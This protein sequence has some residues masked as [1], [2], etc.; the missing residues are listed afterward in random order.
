ME[1]VLLEELNM[2]NHPNRSR[3]RNGPS[4][5]EVKAERERVQSI[6]D[7][8]ITAAQD[9]CAAAVET[10]RRAFQQWEDGDRA[11]LPGLFKLLQI[12]VRA[13]CGDDSVGALSECSTPADAR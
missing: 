7:C 6:L 8:G 3:R 10:S 12:E 11:M 1:N 4:A 5:D 9:W 2:V 13:L